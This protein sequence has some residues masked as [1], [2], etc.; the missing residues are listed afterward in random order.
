MRAIAVPTSPD[1]AE[2]VLAFEEN[3]FDIA[4]LADLNA[5]RNTLQLSLRELYLILMKGSEPRR[6]NRARLARVLLAMMTVARDHYASSGHQ[7]YWPFLF[8]QIDEVI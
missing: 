3:E 1:D 7:E 5:D 6:S 4:G 8:D 2:L